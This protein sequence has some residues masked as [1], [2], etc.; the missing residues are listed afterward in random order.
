M[1]VLPFLFAT[2]QFEVTKLPSEVARWLVLAVA[3]GM[4]VLSGMGRGPGKGIGMVMAD[5]MA[6][7]FLAFFAVTAV[8]AIDGGYSIQRTISFVLL[9]LAAFW[10]FWSYADRFGEEQLLQLLLRTA[11]VILGGNLLIVGVL[12]PGTILARRFQGFFDNPNNI[13]LIC[14]LSLPLVFS[15]LLRKR[16]YWQWGEFAVLFLSLLACG[17]R[18][19]L[20]AS[21]AGMLLIGALRAARGNRLAILFAVVLVVVI[22]LLS[23]THFFEDNVTRAESMETFSNRTGFWEMARLDYIPKRPWHGHGFGT[24]GMIHE[25]YGISLDSLQL[26]GYGVMS[27]YYGL[28]VAVGI[29]A[30][31]LFYLALVGGLVSSLRKYWW[32]ARLVAL[33]AMVIAGLLVGITESAI[34][35]VGNCFA[36]L[37]WMGFML[38]MRRSMYRR[39]RVPMTAQG[40]LRLSSAKRRDRRPRSVPRKRLEAAI[41]AN[42]SL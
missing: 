38:M 30:T 1:F 20:I 15:D 40:A 4:A 28:A 9:Y 3:V 10:Y 33:C 17:S 27:S 41:P 2:T 11:S 7:A 39:M 35:S 23:L 22:G 13:G 25:Y 21:M 42:V 16:G 31:I 32:D 12:A 19:G 18:T 6:L 5:Y 36:Y 8:W 24:D 34:Y 14:A 37:F 26:R 29:P